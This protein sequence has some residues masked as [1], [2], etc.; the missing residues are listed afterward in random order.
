MVTKVTISIYWATASTDGN[1]WVCDDPDLLKL[2]NIFAG[3][4]NVKEYTP[5][6]AYSMA[7]LA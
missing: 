3:A 1:T 6:R 5:S 2:L 4:D 7:M